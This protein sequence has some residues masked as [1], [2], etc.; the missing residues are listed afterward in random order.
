MVFAA[1]T[2]RVKSFNFLANL[3]QFA[4][5]GLCGVFFP[6]SILPTPVRIVSLAIPFTYYAD[7]MRYTAASQAAGTTT[8]FDPAFE[9]TIAAILS[10]AVFLLGLAYFKATEKSAQDRGTIGTH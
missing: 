6:L 4:V 9:F 7:L 10:I 2:F 3:T 1:V 8:I 5:I